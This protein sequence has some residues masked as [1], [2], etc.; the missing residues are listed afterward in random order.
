[1]LNRLKMKWVG[2]VMVVIG[3]GACAMPARAAD[4]EHPRLLVAATDIQKIRDRVKQEPYASMVKAI[5]KQLAD[6]KEPKDAGALMYDDQAVDEASMFVLTG[7]KTAAAAAEKIVLAMVNDKDFWNNPGSKGLTRAGGALR[8]ALAYDLCYEAWPESTRTLVSQKLRLAADQMMKGMG[9]GANTQLANNWQ[10]VRYGAAGLAFLGSDEAGGVEAAKNAFE[11]LKRHLNANLGG[12]GW[13]PEGIGYTQYPWQFTGPFGIAAQRA[14]LGDLRQ[15]VKRAGL[16]FWA[17]YA[18]TINI[19]RVD[20]VG[21]RSDLSDDHP[22]WSGEGTAG[23]GF[24]YAPASQ[25][26]G[27]RFMYDYLCGPNGDKSWDSKAHGGLYS[28][29]YYPVDTPAKNP[30]EVEGLGLNYT[31]KSAGIAIFRNAFKDENDIV[32][33]VNGHGRQPV[34]CHGGPDTDTFRILGLGGCWAVGSGRTADSAG[35][36]NLF[37]GKPPAKQPKGESNLGKLDSIDFAKDGGGVAV[38]SGS[39]VGVTN[40]RRVFAVDF[41]GKSGATAVFVSAETSD[42]GAIWRLNTPEFNEITSSGNN[43]TLKGPTG[44]TLIATVIS[45]GKVTFRTGTF[46]RGGGAGHVGYPY[47]GTKYINNKWIEFDCDKT[48]LIVMTLQPKGTDAPKV[49]GDGS[50]TKASLK[51]G[52]QSVEVEDA[53]VTFGG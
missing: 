38:T 19:P 2:T 28:I 40:Q 41:S 22:V 30:A 16:T 26:A 8:A 1:M 48:V 29:L 53:K 35:Q 33:L 14:G 20:G 12:N 21:L 52:S 34:G 6:A 51:V 44:S 36:T 49:T 3:I 43:F 42:N 31:D 32:A 27:M 9:A 46:E 25:I 45:P 24:W 23:L 10:A 39:C 18:G 4:A 15:E 17:T 5:Q 50:A 7:D 11:H 47:R 13:N 37:A